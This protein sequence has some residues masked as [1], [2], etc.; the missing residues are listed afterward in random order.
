MGKKKKKDEYIDD[1]HTVYNMDIEGF[2]WHDR[3]ARNA[4]KTEI[5]KKARRALIRSA[6]KSYLPPVLM[7]LLGFS[8]AAVLL[9][10]WLR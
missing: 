3:K 8:L 2:R 5:S 7:I 1:G 4:N 9:Y 6:Y 10:F